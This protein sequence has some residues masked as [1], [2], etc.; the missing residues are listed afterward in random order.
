MTGNARTMGRFGPLGNFIKT[1][2]KI[3]ATCK[4]NCRKDRR[5]RICRRKVRKCEDYMREKLESSH[6]EKPIKETAKNETVVSGEDLPLMDD[7]KNISSL[8]PN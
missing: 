5:G 3:A 7:G 6:T 4:R 1:A 8:K 2:Q